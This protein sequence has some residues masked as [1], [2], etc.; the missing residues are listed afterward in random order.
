MPQDSLQFLKDSTQLASEVLDFIPPEKVDMSP[1]GPGWYILGGI[2]I[3][4]VLIVVIREYNN[5]LGTTYKRVANRELDKI[6]NE[7]LTLQE[8]IFQINTTLKRVAITTYDRDQVAPLNG[9]EWVAFLNT[10]WKNNFSE[11]ESELLI[12][13]A[14]MKFSVDHEETL[15]Q[16]I[17]SSKKWIKSHV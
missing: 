4:L 1:T 10:H 8:S 7:K 13:G 2:A 12:N 15:T 17:Q 11:K 5:Y 6:L 9:E 3:L 16:L 14:Y